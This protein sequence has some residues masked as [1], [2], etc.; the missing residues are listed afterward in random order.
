MNNIQEKVNEVKGVMYDNISQVMKRDEK[1][2]LMI[3]K[4]DSLKHESDR[5]MVN[6]K[7]TK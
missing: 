1:I 4:T 2:H 6:S 3:D 7:K 5:F